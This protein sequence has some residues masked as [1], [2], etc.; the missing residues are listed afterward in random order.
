MPGPDNMASN[1]S[2]FRNVSVQDQTNNPGQDGQ[3]NSSGQDERRNSQYAPAVQNFIENL[4]EEERMLIIL[5]AELYEGSWPAMLSDLENRLDGRPFIFKLANRIK[6]DI[7]RIEK[8]WNFETEH[9]INLAD[10]AKPPSKSDSE[11]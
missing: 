3:N 1:L 6:E 9:K 11:R 10:F 2:R 5:K 4:H 7:A 8:L